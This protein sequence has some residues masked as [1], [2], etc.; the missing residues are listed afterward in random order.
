MLCHADHP[1]QQVPQLDSTPSGTTDTLATTLVVLSYVHLLQTL[2]PWQRGDG[3][4]EG[5]N[6]VFS[7]NDYQ[8]PI[9][10][11]LPWQPEIE[12]VLSNQFPK[13]MVALSLSIV[14]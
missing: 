13:M 2:G 3:G 6:D 8:L 9:Y 11:S 7:T 5:G 10:G 4:W 14:P 12:D 1:Q